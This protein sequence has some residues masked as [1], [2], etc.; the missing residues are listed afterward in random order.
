MGDRRTNEH[1]IGLPSEVL[2]IGV[3]AA[4]A[5]QAGVFGAGD[6]L[7]DRIGARAE[8][9]VFHDTYSSG[10]RRTVAQ[11]RQNSA[12][13]RAFNIVTKDTPIVSSGKPAQPSKKGLFSRL[14][15]VT[16]AARE[17][18]HDFFGELLKRIERTRQIVQ[19]D[20][21]HTK[22]I[23]LFNPLYHLFR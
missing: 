1:R 7:A 13:S 20:V 11:F 12:S 15:S 8:N 19:Q 22:L 3:S 10:Q 14:C 4:A 9:H 18:R 16:F 23:Q 2:V 21:A 17:M 6:G 5:Q